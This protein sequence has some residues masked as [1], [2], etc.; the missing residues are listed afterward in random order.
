MTSSSSILIFGLQGSS[1][2]FSAATAQA[3]R[4]HVEQNSSLCRTILDE[5]TK[6]LLADAPALGLPVADLFAKTG[7]I[8]G[9][10]STEINHNPLF[11]AFFISLHQF[12]AV[13]ADFENSGRSFEAWV[14]DVDETVG[15]CSGLLP[16]AVLA[17]AS[18]KE[19]FLGACTQALRASLWIA[20][21]AAPLTPS[22][23]NTL[24]I[25]GI[26]R[27]ELEIALSKDE[28][29]VALSA[30]LNETSYACTGLHL[31]QLRSRLPQ[32]THTQYA[33]VNGWY[34]RGPAHEHLIAAVM[35]SLR[36][37]RVTFD[38]VLQRPLRLSSDGQRLPV[39]SSALEPI[40][41]HMLLLPIDFPQTAKALLADHH[42]SLPSAH[43]FIK[44][45]GPAPEPFLN[46]LKS[47]GLFDTLASLE[48]LSPFSL[49]EPIADTDIAIVGKA[50]D[51]PGAH[52]DEE[53][54][55]LLS[56]RICTVS[57][58]R[59]SPQLR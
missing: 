27:A 57:E 6:A 43:I 32:D 20:N 39:A 8:L 2:V 29:S 18:T 46:D 22:Q 17:S 15:F 30:I 7:D 45:F 34:H 24:V 54:I 12:I 38:P 31:D 1:S 21:A 47:Q 4:R 51:F 37:R 33:S 10:H 25:A 55:S 23:S 50:F 28:D 48:D 58:V 3:T 16:A 19:E 49:T 44:S 59:A 5:A 41:R 36:V 9:P 53:L 56:S 26:K 52:N 35:E 14:G 40:L 42:G 13:A 11:Q